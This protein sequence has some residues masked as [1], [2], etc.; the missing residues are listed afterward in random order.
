MLAFLRAWPSVSYP[1]TRMGFGFLLPPM[2]FLS[3]MRENEPSQLVNP[4]LS[5]LPFLGLLYP[6][7]LFFPPRDEILT[8]RKT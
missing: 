5:F 1:L 3:S 7:L 4:P 8:S 2:Y 6:I